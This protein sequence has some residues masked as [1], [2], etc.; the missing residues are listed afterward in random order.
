MNGVINKGN[1]AYQT[2]CPD[3]RTQFHVFG[4]S[5][6]ERHAIYSYENEDN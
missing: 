2:C 5:L 1:E 6:V 3:S 4:A